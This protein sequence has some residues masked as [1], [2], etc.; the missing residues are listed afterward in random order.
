MR[1]T[2]LSFG[3][4]AAGVLTSAHA[5]AADNAE[6]LDELKQG[7][8]LKQVGN[9]RDAVPHLTHSVRLQATARALL[10]LSDCEQKLGELLSAQGHAAQGR[11]MAGQQNDGELAALADEQLAAIDKRLP[12]LTV[13]LSDQAPAGSKVACDGVPVDASSLGAPIPKNTGAHIVTV[14]APGRAEKRFDVTMD[15]GGHRELTVEP[16]PKLGLEP[17]D[18]IPSEAEAPKSEP[19]SQRANL[20][21]PLALAAFGLGAAGLAVGLVTGIMGG[22]KHAALTTECPQDLCPSSAHGDLDAF[23]T[24]R[25]A[26]TVGYVVGALGVAG[27]AVLWLTAPSGRATRATARVWLGPSSAGVGGAF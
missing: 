22:S 24:L 16:G 6:A 15:E 4:A 12:R 25:T 17:P 11:E 20:S 13:R 5:Q 19:G 8:S 18:K 27:G 9:C 10:N 3:L 14:S 1:A 21:K 7:Y 26:S 23:H 2:I